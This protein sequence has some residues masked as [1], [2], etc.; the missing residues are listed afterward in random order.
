M[1]QP[2]H[3][4]QWLQLPMQSPK[5]IDAMVDEVANIAQVVYMLVG[6]RYLQSKH[7]LDRSGGSIDLPQNR[8]ATHSIANGA[9]FR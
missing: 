8:E 9:I 7:Q 6:V 4:D 2:G 3:I 1:G 5:D